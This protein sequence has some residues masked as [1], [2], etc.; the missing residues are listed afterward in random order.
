MFDVNG[1]TWTIVLASPEHPMLRLKNGRHTIGVCDDAQKRIYINEE[2]PLSLMGK[3]LRHEIAHAVL[4][5]HNVL[6]SEKDE[7]LIADVVATYGQEI[8]DIF[9][10]VTI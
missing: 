4:F 7:E 9:N 10:R 3:V 5:S 6:L 8:I 1:E 2:L